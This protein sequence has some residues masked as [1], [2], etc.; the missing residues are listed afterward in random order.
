MFTPKVFALSAGV[1]A[2]ALLAGGPTA[3]AQPE[4]AL[5]QPATPHQIAGW[6]ISIP[7]SG[8]A[9]PD[10]RGTVAQG[11]KVYQHQCASCHGDKGQG[12]S[13]GP[14][15]VGGR[16]TLDTK[17]PV[18]TV[19]SYWPYATT[20]F[21]YVRRAMPFNAPES[22]SADQVYAVTAYVL[23]LNGIVSKNA[24]MD[25]KTLPKV[26][27]PNRNG[28]IQPDPRPDVRNMACERDCAPQ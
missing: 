9:L 10:G 8:E 21:D 13:I 20:V 15:L 11:K 22:L 18:K 1:F 7:P 5:G 19:G 27:M 3:G 26:K 28:F 23:H 17:H 16:G 4:Y 14:K 25:A 24:V 12:G 6:N 2:V